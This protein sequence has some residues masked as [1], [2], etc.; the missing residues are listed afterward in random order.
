MSQRFLVT[1][2]VNNEVAFSSSCWGEHG[3]AYLIETESGKILFDTG[4]TPEVLIHNLAAGR[5]SLD[6]LAAVVLSHG[7]NDHTG[8]LPFLLETVSPLTII[9]S[10][11]VFGEKYSSRHDPPGYIGIPVRR[12]D[13]ERRARLILQEELYPVREGVSVTGLIPLETAF[14]TGDTNL[15]VRQNGQL[16]PDP[17]VDDR[18]LVLEAEAGLVVV[19]GCCHAGLINTLRYVQRHFS[20]PVIAVLGGSHLK[21]AGPERIQATIEVLKQEFPS[22]QSLRLNHC[23]GFQA[24]AALQAAFGPRVQPLLAGETVVF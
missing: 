8:G 21:P 10:P 15:L 3:L 7:H 19:L 9:A 11:D 23:T 4:Q 12:A 20:R 14:E 5:K 24:L 13:L 1:C 16:V 2:L 18:T 6:H 22:I 17:V